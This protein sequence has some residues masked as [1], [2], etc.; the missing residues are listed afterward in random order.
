MPTPTAVGDLVKERS[1]VLMSNDGQKFPVSE[2][3][4]FQSLLLKTLIND[5]DL[6]NAGEDK[7]AEPLPT[8]IEDGW[9]LGKIMQWCETHKNEVFIPKEEHEDQ[10]ITLTAA[11]EEYLT[12]YNSQ[13]MDVLLVRFFLLFFL[14][15]EISPLTFGG[16]VR[17]LYL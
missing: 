6:P 9:A 7:R 8:G 10:R 2:K 15:Q 16:T 17:A 12:M 4:A 13:L 3:A 5:M 11:D 14:S 1:Y